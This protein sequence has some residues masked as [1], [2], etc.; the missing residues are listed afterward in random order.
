MNI[1]GFVEVLPGIWYE[2]ST[3]FPWTT[4]YLASLGGKHGFETK[5]DGQ[6]KLLKCKHYYGYSR[7]GIQK[8]KTDVW[9][10]IIYNYFKG[11]ISNGLDVDH[12]NNNVEDNRIENLQ[13]ISHKSNSRKCKINR[14]NKS[15]Y[16]GVS[17]CVD[18]NKWQSTI[19]VDGKKVALGRFN[20]AK[21]A[22]QVYIS[23]KIKYHGI[24][25]VKP[26]GEVQ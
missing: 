20:D 12:I 19:V 26:L 7:I 13:L 10:R 4:K 23:A 1:S 6:L 18:R 14:R 3:G 2:E 22:Y 17:W 25:S 15:G 21:D 11:S 5:Y 9:H 16:A 8:G 24:D